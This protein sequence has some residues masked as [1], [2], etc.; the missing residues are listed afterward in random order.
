MKTIAFG[1]GY[2]ERDPESHTIDLPALAHFLRPVLL[3]EVEVSEPFFSVIV[4]AYCETFNA[5]KPKCLKVEQAARARIERSRTAFHGPPRQLF[6]YCERETHSWRVMEACIRANGVRRRDGDGRARGGAPDDARSTGRSE[7][8]MWESRDPSRGTA[9]E[10]APLIEKAAP[11]PP[12]VQVW[13]PT[14]TATTPTAPETDGPSQ[15]IAPTDADRHVKGVLERTGVA[16]AM[17]TKKQ[18][19]SGWV[20]V[21]EKAA[22]TPRSSN[23]TR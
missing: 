17:C 19:G 12:N 18:Y 5:Q 16:D 14:T 9:P 4:V 8:E 20:T 6:E 10:A 1:P 23:S 2:E 3:T 15:P 22:P 7:G 11:L 13:G 21:C